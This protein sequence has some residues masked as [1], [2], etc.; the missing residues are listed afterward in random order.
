MRTKVT[1]VLIFLNVALFFFIFKFERNWRT[2]A[3]SLEARRRVLGQ[4]AANIRSLE[5][6]RTVGGAVSLVRNR[7]NWFLTK[8]LDWPANPHA[9]SSVLHDLQL[10]EHETS[11]RVADLAKTNQSLADYG[12]DQPRIT[13]AFSSGD[14][15]AGAG[16]PPP[17][18]V[19]R[20]GDLTKDGKR[21]YI[22][23]PDGERVHVVGRALIDSLSFPLEQLRADTLLT[24][25]VFEARSLGVQTANPEQDRSGAATGV[26]TRIRRDGARWAFE[27]PIIARASKTAVDLAINN[28][29]ALQPLSF[30]PPPPAAA[31]SLAPELR[32]TIE[33]NNRHET[34][35]LGERIPPTAGQPATTPPTIGYYAQLEG[36]NALFTVAVPASLVDSLRNA[37]ESL[38]EKRIL[39]F[40]P[41]SVTAITLASPL[42][43]GATLTLQR[44]DNPPG[45]APEAAA[46]WQIIERGDGAQAPRPWPADRAAV[47][48]LLEMLTLLSAE[49]FKS[50]APS[51][52]DLEDWGFNRPERE[53]R[54]TLSSSATSTVLS[55]GTDA[56][57]NVYARVGTPTDPGSSIYTVNLDLG[58]EFP[59]TALAWRDRNLR[60]PLPAGARFTSLKLTDLETKQVVFETAFGPTGEPTIPASDPKALTDLL[61]QLRALRARSILQ[62]GFTERVAVAGDERPWRYQLEAGVALP[63]GAGG[64]LTSNLNLL[65]TERLSGT[66]QYAGAKDL[67]L[68]FA[69][70]Q[71]F[72]DAIWSLTSRDLIPPGA[73]AVKP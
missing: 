16:A 36:R 53:V 61:A 57:R 41:R 18:T 42:Q 47:Q 15:A 31:P 60:E 35:F 55:F 33:G 73:P 48:R 1:L 14:N 37:Q 70:E 56:R 66:E 24:I 68:V 34:L 10:L 30:S 65:L 8:P 58:R 59:I 6:N 49:N 5:I 9:V 28:L 13:V 62:A 20:I 2:E 64:E 45:A 40:D 19:L 22:L 32:I 26:R 27:T 11:F 7:D 51:R 63:G 12:L 72:L 29:N 71:P 67:D 50:D 52:A 43:S 21:L 23:S 69:L 25:P 46:P 39:D 54:L 44:L 38:R 4:E 3:A 17:P